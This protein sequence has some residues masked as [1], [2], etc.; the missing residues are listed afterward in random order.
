[1]QLREAA[2]KGGNALLAIRSLSSRALLNYKDQSTTKVPT[3]STVPSLTLNS[4][5]ALL[6]LTL[7]S[8]TMLMNSS[9]TASHV[10]YSP[11]PLPRSGRD[12]TGP[13]TFVQENTTQ[14]VI[15]PVSASE[16]AS[17]PSPTASS[18]LRSSSNSSETYGVGRQPVR[19]HRASNLSKSF[20]VNDTEPEE[21]PRSRRPSR[22]GQQPMRPLDNTGRFTSPLQQVMVPQTSESGGG[23]STPTLARNRS[24]VRHPEDTNHLRP[25][26]GPVLDAAGLHVP[27]FSHPG[28]ILSVHEQQGTIPK[29][30]KPFAFQFP[31]PAPSPPSVSSVNSG[32]RLL[33]PTRATPKENPLSALVSAAGLSNSPTPDPMHS[34]ASLPAA[35][36]PPTSPSQFSFN[37]DLMTYNNHTGASTHSAANSMDQ[38]RPVDP[39]TFFLA[40]PSRHSLQVIGGSPLQPEDL[41]SR[42]LRVGRLKDMNASISSFGTASSD[43]RAPSWTLETL[44]ENL[45][46]HR[47]GDSSNGSASDRSSFN[48]A[49]FQ[50]PQVAGAGPSGGAPAVRP[51]SFHINPQNPI[52][53]RTVMQTFQPLLPDEL[54]LHVGEQLGVLRHFDDQWCITAREMLP[55]NP[56]VGGPPGLNGGVLEIGA[57]PAWVFESQQPPEGFARPMRSSSLGIT[58]SVRVPTPAPMPDPAGPLKPWA[59]REEVISWSNF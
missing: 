7:N 44:R 56:G 57:C 5:R 28:D 1:M 42:G 54:G 4:T 43:P 8:R 37:T 23:P 47:R 9:S 16:P 34:D 22:V 50:F 3:V 58:V 48:V 21:E 25:P 6:L 29:P 26:K 41:E 27:S 33:T 39:N 46:A 59:M 45:F 52:E 38:Y 40:D 53:M 49:D 51:Q 20:S 12:P 2:W 55:S 31:R 13:K 32:P 35:P 36:S 19:P 15:F 17:Q 18:Q 30:F 24:T 10:N 14:S 11:S